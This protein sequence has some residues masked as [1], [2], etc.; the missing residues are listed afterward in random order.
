MSFGKKNF[1]FLAENLGKMLETW[2]K[3]LRNFGMITSR[4]ILNIFMKFRGKFEK[5]VAN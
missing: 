2:R 5:T 4:S 3:F 1:E